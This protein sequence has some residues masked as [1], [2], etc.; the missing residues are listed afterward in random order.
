MNS[1]VEKALEFKKK[2]HLTIAWRVKKNASVIDKHLN[3]GE[4]VLYVFAGQR[5]LYRHDIF[6]TAVI[7]LT[8]KRIIVGRK[9]VLFGYFIDTITP[10]MFNDFN[11]KVGLLFGRVIIDTIK[12]KVMIAD[13]SAKAM[14]EVETA[15]SET[16]IM[17]KKEYNAED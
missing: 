16:M 4:E 13:I 9:R 1:V 3:P 8:N 5:Q 17:L 15:L 7:A 2:Y 11:I 14:P 12:E 10:D 6:H